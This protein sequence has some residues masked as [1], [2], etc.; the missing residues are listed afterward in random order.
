MVGKLVVLLRIQHLKQ[1]T[2]RIATEIAAHLVDFIK[3]EQ[4]IFHTRFRHVLQDFARHRAD[5]GTAVASDF[6]FITHAAQRHTHIL[7]ACGFGNRLTQGSFTH[8]RRT[9]Q[10]QN[11]AFELVHTF[12]NSQIFQNTLF[13]FFQTIVVGIQNQISLGNI[14][15]DTGFFPPRQLKQSIDIVA[16]DGRFRRHRRHHFQFFQF[17]QTFFFSFFAHTCF[18]D[19]VLQR[20]QLTTLVFFAQLF[21]NRFHLLIQVILALGFFH[22][23]FHTAT[24]TFLDLH[25]VEFGFQLSQQKFQ[26]FNNAGSLQHILTLLQFQLQMRGNSIGKTAVV[27]DTA[28]GADDFGR[29]FFVQLR[30]LLKLSQ[31]SPTQGLNFRIVLVAVFINRLNM[32]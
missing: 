12:L 13:D 8:P 10:T 22:L 23:T 29:D 20:I 30:I 18:F 21:L 28:D 1:C 25:D 2:G 11:R 31:Q 17:R 27:I 24:D 9:N 4:W 32:R 7:S 6:A 19:F 3:Q 5:I 16:H 15:A 14:F 26:T